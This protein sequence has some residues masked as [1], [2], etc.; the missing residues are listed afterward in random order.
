MTDRQLDFDA[1]MHLRL[2]QLAKIHAAGVAPNPEGLVGREYRG[3]NRPASS[4]LLGIRRFIKGFQ[5]DPNGGVH[6]YNKTVRGASLGA[7][8][9]ASRRKDGRV[10]YAP[11]L[12]LPRPEARGPGLLLDYGAPATPEP[13]F[14]HRL[15]D[16]LVRV[17]PTSD[18]LLLGR[19]SHSP[20][21]GYPSAGSCSSTWGRRTPT[22][23]ETRSPRPVGR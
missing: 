18:D 19:T 7:A 1:L 9:T 13:G 2:R 21:A 10:A 8:W 4:A 17:D 20:V 6:G 5:A 23:A 22:A 14:A 3:A 16:L 12:V 11:F 15:R